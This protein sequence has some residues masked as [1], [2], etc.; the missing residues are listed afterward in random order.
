MKEIVFLAK[1]CH[2]PKEEI[3]SEKEIDE[4]SKDAFLILS[5]AFSHFLDS[6]AESEGDREDINQGTNSL[7][8]QDSDKYYSSLMNN[9]SNEEMWFQN[10]FDNQEVPLSENLSKYDEL[11]IQQNDSSVPIN[12]L[13]SE[14]SPVLLFLKELSAFLQQENLNK[15]H[16]G[17]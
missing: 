16:Y 8:K 2:T 9:N 3:L 17:W 14:I 1:G 4:Q 11:R 13:L 5:K 7:L 10:R 6:Y 15:R 12:K